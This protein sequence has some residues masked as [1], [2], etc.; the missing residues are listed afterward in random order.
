MECRA[1]LVATRRRSLPPISASTGED[2][3]ALSS[4]ACQRVF[5]SSSLNATTPALVAPMGRMTALSVRRGEETKPCQVELL[6]N[7]AFAWRDQTLAPS[8][9]SRHV[10]YPSVL[11]T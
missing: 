2:A 7:S 4:S 11:K 10:R 6:L 8:F 9:M 5:P 3:L 1:D